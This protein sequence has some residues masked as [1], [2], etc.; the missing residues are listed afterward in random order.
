MEQNSSFIPKEDN[1]MKYYLDELVKIKNNVDGYS[2]DHVNILIGLVIFGLILDFVLFGFIWKHPV[3][4]IIIF[5][6][7][8]FLL[9]ALM[10]A[11]KIWFGSNMDNGKDIKEEKKEDKPKSDSF[12]NILGLDKLNLPSYQEYEKSTNKAFS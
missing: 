7:L 6:F 5:L 3:I 1:K 12:E 10:V 4:M 9:G 2:V 8:L 11:K